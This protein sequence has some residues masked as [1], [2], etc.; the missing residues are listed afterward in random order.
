[1]KIQSAPAATD[2][3]EG[4]PEASSDD[5]QEHVQVESEHEDLLDNGELSDAHLVRI[6][7]QFCGEIRRA[8]LSKNSQDDSSVIKEGM[9]SRIVELQTGLRRLKIFSEQPN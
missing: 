5:S 7:S 8:I 2:D 4:H 1:M 6:R 3:N 9:L